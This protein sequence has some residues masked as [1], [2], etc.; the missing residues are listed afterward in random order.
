[1][2]D[3]TQIEVK[4]RVSYPFASIEVGGS[5]PGPK[6]SLAALCTRNNKKLHPKKFKTKTEN[7]ETRVIRVE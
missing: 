6:N 3:E 4:Q 1:M 7:G 5:F 2:T